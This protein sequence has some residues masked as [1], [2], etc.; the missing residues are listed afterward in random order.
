MRK[1]DIKVGM[2]VEVRHDYPYRTCAIEKIEDNH[3][4]ISGYFAKGLDMKQT[5]AVPLDYFSKGNNDRNSKFIL[6][7]IPEYGESILVSNDE[8]A[9]FI[10]SFHSFDENYIG[11]VNTKLSSLDDSYGC[12]VGDH[13]NW[14]H[15]KRIKFLNEKD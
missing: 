8:K 4:F 10:R 3:F 9:W 6:T 15:Y 1:E 2:Q 13:V 11:N 12:T 14:K 7:N 5:I